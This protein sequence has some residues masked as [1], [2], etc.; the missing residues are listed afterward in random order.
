MDNLRCGIIKKSGIIISKKWNNIKCWDW[1][2]YWWY[3]CTGYYFLYWNWIENISLWIW[4]K[5][6][7]IKYL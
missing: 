4:T 5:S 2:W 1:Y 3:G 7:N 6:R